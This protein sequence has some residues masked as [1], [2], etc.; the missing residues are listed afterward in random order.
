MIDQGNLFHISRKVKEAIFF[1][2]NFELP[3]IYEL[4]TLKNLHESYKW[5]AIKQKKSSNAASLIS[6][7]IDQDEPDFH[8]HS[9]GILK[10]FGAKISMIDPMDPGL[11]SI[12]TSQ[13]TYTKKIETRFFK[14]LDHK[15]SVRIKLSNNQVSFMN[16]FLS[17]YKN[18]SFPRL[19]LDGQFDFDQPIRCAKNS[20]TF[21]VPYS[22]HELLKGLES[23]FIA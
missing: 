8:I 2:E 14:I 22:Q 19:G 23:N 11:Y 13:D 5:I 18:N 20:L 15:N 9:N 4:V 7:P 6:F 1:K 17:L 10:E 21:F 3:K 16:K 12:I